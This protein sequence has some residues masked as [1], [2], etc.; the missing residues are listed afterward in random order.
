MTKTSTQRLAEILLGQ[1]LRKWIADRRAAG[2]S[3]DRIA[4]ELHDRTGGQVSVSGEAIRQWA[5]KDAA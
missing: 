2:L 1:P 4:V 3:Y 5:A